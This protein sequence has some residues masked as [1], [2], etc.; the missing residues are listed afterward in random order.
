MKK[1]L[2]LVFLLLLIFTAGCSASG[3]AADTV[4][5][6]CTSSKTPEIQASN[7]RDMANIGAVI[8][9]SKEIIEESERA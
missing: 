1:N 4:L 6:D 7:L 8:A 2:I 3:P 9:S 5:S